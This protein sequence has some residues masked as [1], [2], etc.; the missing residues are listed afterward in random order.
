M[1]ES[2]RLG[3]NIVVF[4]DLE[5]LRELNEKVGGNFSIS[6]KKTWNERRL[7]FRVEVMKADIKDLFQLQQLGQ[8]HQLERLRNFPK[9]TILNCDFRDVK[10]QTPI[11]ETI[12]YLDP[13]YRNTA[14]YLE[15]VFFEDVDNYFR[16]IP[17]SCFMSEYDASFDS[18]LEIRAISRLCATEK[19]K[20]VI[21]KLFWNKK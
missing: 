6:N 18:I 3:H 11:E 19:R 9:L 21:E 10:I 8:L 12:V 7:D 20:F 13:P 14:E 1:E 16:S 15:K 5:A 2:K 4:Q 17:Y